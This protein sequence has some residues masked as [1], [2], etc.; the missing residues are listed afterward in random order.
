MLLEFKSFRKRLFLNQI[1]FGFKYN[2]TGY[3]WTDGVVQMAMPYKFMIAFENSKI[4]GY[5][6][7]KIFNALYAHTIPIYFGMNLCDILVVD[8]V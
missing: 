3:G 6:T 7:E 2:C 5:S 1:E 8:A 4:K